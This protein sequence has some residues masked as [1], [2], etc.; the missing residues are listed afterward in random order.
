MESVVQDRLSAILH[1]IDEWKKGDPFLEDKMGFLDY[2]KTCDIGHLNVGNTKIWM[3]YYR[4]A[5]KQ[6]VT[7][8]ELLFAMKHDLVVKD[9]DVIKREKKPIKERI[10]VVSEDKQKELQEI[11]SRLRDDDPLR[12][13]R[14]NK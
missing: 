2:L 5:R 9:L 1:H 13:K 14:L 8:P 11:R 3:S 6:R 7:V 4:R 10:F 12:R